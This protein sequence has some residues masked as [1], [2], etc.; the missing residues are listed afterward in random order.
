MRVEALYCPGP[1]QVDV[2]VLDLPAGSTLGQALAAS[3]LLQRH[4]L[5]ADEVKAGVW[6]RVKPLDTVLREGDRVE[7]YRPLTVDPKEARRLRYKRQRA[8]PQ[9]AAASGSPKR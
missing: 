3:G 2:Q 4:G 5:L 8:E 1:G 9:A 7:L 6:S